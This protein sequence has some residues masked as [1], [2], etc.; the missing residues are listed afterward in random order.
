MGKITQS[1]NLKILILTLSAFAISFLW[2]TKQSATNDLTVTV[3]GHTDASCYSSSDGSID[4]S[5]SGGDGNY[6][7]SWEDD[8][9]SEISTDEDPSGLSSGT[10]TV[11]VTD[12]NGLTGTKSFTITAPEELVITNTP[13]YEKPTCKG[14][15]DGSIIQISHTG[16]T[17]PYKYNIDGGTY[18]NGKTFNNLG[19]GTY[20]IGVKDDNNCTATME[21]TISEP[22][23]LVLS[24]SSVTNVSCNGLSDGQISA[25]LATGGTGPY[26]YKINGSYQTS[27][28]FSGLPAGTYSITVKDFYGCTTSESNI[29]IT[30]PET[31]SL[32][33]STATNV[34]CNG[35]ND[36]TIT[37]G[38]VT[39]GNSNFEYSI[40]GIN[41]SSQT[42]FTGLTAGSYSISVKD[43]MECIA[44][45]TITIT[46]PAPLALAESVFTQPSCNGDSD[47]TITVGSVSGGT[48][49]Y[50]YEVTG[51]NAQASP[52]FTGF[53]SGTYDITITDANECVITDEI[54]IT[55]PDV[56][57]IQN[58]TS[59]PVSCFGGN[60]GTVTAGTITGGNDNFEYSIDGGNF[61]TSNIFSG[62][63]EGD[64]IVTV[65]D[66]EG[67]EAS[68]TVYVAEPEELILT[69]SEPSHISCFGAN[70]GEISIGSVAGGNDDYTYSL[71]G[72]DFGTQTTFTGL[73]PGSHYITVTDSKNCTA[74][75]DFVIN[76]P[77][78][79]QITA[80]TS[81]DVSCNGGTDGTLTAGNVSGGTP[82]YSYS[83]DGTTFQDSA[84]FT[85]LTAGMYTVIIEDAQG[86]TIEQEIEII[87]P[88]PLDIPDANIQITAVSC[89]GGADGE[90]TIT[91]ANGGNGNY[92]YG[93]NGGTV[94][95][96][97][98]F[99]G[100]SAGDHVIMVRDAKNCEFTKTIT[101]SEPEVL[102]MT[103]PTA[104]DA[105]CY[106][107]SDG[108]VTAGTVSG[109]TAPYQY[110][111]DNTNFSAATTFTNL[112]AGN[113]T[114]FVVDAN[115]CA[116]QQTI[117]VD[118][119]EEITASIEKTD[120][121]CF[122]GSDGTI[123][124][125]NAQGGN[126]SYEYSL[127][128]SNWQNSN[129]F[130][131]LTAGDYPVYIRDASVTGCEIV[132]DDAF[133]ISQPSE[134]LTIE[135]TATRTT[136]YGTATGS[137]TANVTGGT[138][139]YS[140]EW[141]LIGNGNTVIARTKNIN[142]MLA[143]DYE[144]S[145]TDANGCIEVITVSI[146]DA[147]FAEILPKSICEGDMDATRVS[148]YSVDGGTALGGTG[149]YTYE[150][151]FGADAQSD[152]NGTSTATTTNGAKEYRVNYPTQGVRDITLTVTDDSGESE[153]FTMEQYIGQCYRDNCGSNDIDVSDFYIGDE[154]GNELTL[155]N[156]TIPSDKYLYMSFVGNP[157][158]YS[159]YIE[160]TY[161]IQNGFFGGT[162][163]V[164]T[165]G[166]AQGEQPLD[167]KCYYTNE[168]IPDQARL[169]KIP[170]WS[171]G[172]V[173]TIE[174]IYLTFQNNIKHG[175]ARSHKPKCYGNDDNEQV[176][177][178]L[179]AIA[180]PNTIPCY[181][182]ETGSIDVNAQGGAFPYDYSIQSANG[183][184]QS[185]GTFN[186]L[187][188]GTYTAW[189]RDSKGTVYETDP[190]TIVQPDSEL[191]LEASIT[192]PIT[193]FGDLAAA[194][195][196]ASGGTPFVDENGAEYYEYLW[197]DAAQTTTQEI[198]GLSGGNYTVTVVDANGCQQLVDVVIDEPEKLTIPVTGPDQTLGCGGNSVTLSGNIP[199]IGNGKWIVL[200]ES[201]SGYTLADETDP[202]SEFTAP[203]GVYYLQWTITNDDNTCEE[204]TSEPLM[205]TFEGDCSTLDFDGKDDHVVFEGD[206]YNFS[207]GN[208][209]MELWVR[210]KSVNG[211]RTILSKRDYQNINSGGF[212]LVINNGSPTF[213]WG[214]ESISSSSKISTARWHHVAL[215]KNANRYTLYVDGIELA[216]KSGSAIGSVT[217]PFMLGAIHN[218]DDVDDPKDFY[219]GWME[220]LRIWNT[221]I[222]VGQLHFLM[223][224]RVQ[225]SNSKVDGTVLSN[226]LS[227]PNAPTPLDWTSLAGY[228]P[229][230]ANEIVNGK[231]LDEAS[232][233]TDGILKNIDTEQKNS[234]PLPYYSEADGSWRDRSTWDTNIGNENDKF[235]DV[236]HGNGINGKKI[237][238]N[239]VRS[240][241]NMHSN[242][243][244]IHLLGLMSQSGELDMKGNVS[245]TNP[246]G[247]GLTVTHY[248]DLDGIIDLNGESQLVQI[249]GSIL[250]NASSGY[251]ERDQQGTANSFNYNYWSSPV[252]LT[253]NSNNS[254]YKIGTVLM[255]GT[256]PASP[257]PIDF[258]G[259]PYYADAYSFG[260]SAQ[261][262]ISTYWLWTFQD[263]NQNFN[264]EADT[265][266]EWRQV[267]TST[268]L[269]SG[270]GFTMKGTSGWIDVQ[271]R[272]NYTFRGKPNNGDITLNI[273]S[274]QNKLIG[275]PY[276]SAI[277]GFKFIEEN[278]GSTNGSI[279]LWDHF[280]PENS[281]YLV[282]YVG[283]YAAYNK[284]GAVPAIS[285]D[286][287]INATD[288]TGTK[289]PGNYIP[290]G[291][292]F[293][294]STVKAGSGT[295]T[296]SGGTIKFSNSQR[297]FVTEKNKT[298]S[299][300]LMSEEAT[301]SKSSQAEYSKDNRYK[302][303]LKYHS[304]KGYRREILATADGYASNGFD[305]GYDAPL[306][307]NNVEDMYWLIEET[308]FVIQAVPD[309]NPEQI[310]PLGIRIGLEGEFTIGIKELENIDAKSFE[311]Y[312]HDKE[313]DEY[314]D[315]L[316]DDFTATAT[317][318]DYDNRYEIV[319]QAPQEIVE[320]E[321]DFDHD[322]LDVAY[323]DDFKEIQLMNPDLLN[324]Q[325]AEL[326]SL[327]GQ[328]LFSFGELNSEKIQNL[329]LRQQLSTAVYILK[330]YTEDDS[331]SKKLI[332][333]K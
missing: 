255:D 197:N 218:S 30:E 297:L 145:V 41:F 15:K 164:Y 18:Q 141:K 1:L 48:T 305:I 171:C 205:I 57:T 125:A 265:Y 3:S 311:I 100:L 264:G 314:F 77:A 284:S 19:A 33:G 111:I 327:S 326:Y 166:T 201:D 49:P 212:D 78:V 210:P 266:S 162:P 196:T 90:V 74:S 148:Y 39:G 315:L 252:S 192:T 184:F 25:G 130:E 275:N 28:E 138:A 307:E 13:E 213:R 47:G 67:C 237:N 117:K 4:I 207:S 143:G 294:V 177:G 11:L 292:A 198:S 176:N 153:V 262:K 309:F 8:N 219:H 247:N 261:K 84:V 319:F 101:I 43:D 194:E 257:G 51:K 316:K 81:T 159:L 250:D 251:I 248:L 189:V 115:D 211:L 200:P 224:Q 107:V 208:F 24:G 46:E 175:C 215:I 244:D 9:S 66:S 23:E 29:V 286:D 278:I 228:Y 229:L 88:E 102:E 209:S 22:E 174:N 293:F 308:G 137:A 186:N 10:Y 298:D 323:F 195:A 7:Y 91:D 32:S 291:Q 152:E 122:E 127:D 2:A 65:R 289:K 285:N 259:N 68:E 182:S 324:L 163:R 73:T 325:N 142:N 185:S 225:S 270:I 20:V 42:T 146:I 188:A 113:H 287:R 333:T 150:W 52:N 89:N 253:G 40:D 139:P 317:P 44:S 154:N 106:G 288:Q 330:V 301:K 118:E 221:A 82:N 241:H 144:V 299:Q 268:L 103:L 179:A 216:N 140:Y 14:K 234:A 321:F 277:D 136:E 80:G 313:T 123:T 246:T 126:N 274:N 53:S 283:G 147:I 271:E 12:S 155:V 92:R 132:L 129:T 64:H 31:L 55:Q 105:T 114:V 27:T 36:G 6:S 104:T 160:V 226:A 58:S 329:K 249:E 183:P 187:P 180:T 79:M 59:T 318:G 232:S 281:H 131:G 158:R 269:P 217:A 72:N 240:T 95:V 17:G 214:T 296:S 178:P 87:E 134:A 76:E 172:D 243:T 121:N 181:G 167:D 85:G 63:S 69:L 239:I 45:E 157:D 303:R 206:N 222:S 238:W 93:I 54:T 227:L 302:I 124:I 38:S 135:G 203:Q 96:N 62:L 5:V 328:K 35:G 71:D 156:C 26:E 70:D 170:D 312:L 242:D 149:G 331:Y 56:L 94:G 279:Y 280:G 260:S 119:P 151:N 256:N 60:D 133:T 235:W 258:G 332:I 120:V 236:P 199:E 322:F 263:D 112:P 109:G 190:V 168:T 223:N 230:H 295:S 61:T 34:S 220:E 273:G 231:T 110:S 272:Q 233:K 75:I 116:T 320:E 16:G 173:V 202:A 50:T 128:G 169:F 191:A 97:A 300:F 161:V 267:G 98:T 290:V 204:T 165:N 99:T 304:P 282:E 108:T 86:C 83:I 21:V 254:G 306:I 193:C 276:P 37:A 245:K 310:L